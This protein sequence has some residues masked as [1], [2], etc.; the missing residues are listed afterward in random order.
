MVRIACFLKSDELPVPTPEGQWIHGM[1]ES[2][3]SML[4]NTHFQPTDLETFSHW[5]TNVFSLQATNFQ[6]KMRH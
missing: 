2:L 5:L 6:T 1:M 3:V 4:T